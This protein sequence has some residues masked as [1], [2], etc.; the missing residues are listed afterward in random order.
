MVIPDSVAWID[1]WAFSRCSSLTSINIPDGVTYIGEYAF[2]YCSSLTSVVIPDSVTSIGDS[3]F[4]YCSSLINITIGGNNQY[5]KS[6]GS[7]L[8]TNDGK[9]LVQYAIGKEDTSF[10][11]PDNVTS[12]GSSAFSGCDSLTSVVIPDSVAWID[13]WAFSY[14][15][16]L[17]SIN[18]PD[19]VTYIGEYA[20]SYCH[21]LINIT[22]PDSIASMGK[23]AF[24]NNAY[25]NNENNWVDGVLYIGNHLIE[26]KDPILGEY[27]I[28]DGTISIADDA[29]YSCDSLTSVVIPDSVTSIGSYAFAGC[30]SLIS[31]VIPDS[32]VSIDM[33]AFYGCNN[34]TSITVGVNNPNY[35]SID[36]NLYSKDEKTF[37]QYAI[38]K[39]DTSFEIPDSVTSIGEYAFGACS[40]LTN[41]V[42]PDSVISIVDLAFYYCSSLT[43]VVIPDSVT[44][45]GYQAFKHCYNLTDV[46][47]TGTKTEGEKINISSDN[48]YLKNATIHYNYVPEE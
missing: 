19:S 29:F 21:S 13:D 1:D 17:T 46:Y 9:T 18:I 40:S 26:A 38:G 4:G 34:L 39:E 27:V 8:Y 16:S 33:C 6:I 28:K 45:I 11:I 32:V 20:F 48:Y 25:Y 47:Y 36:G 30:D 10:N 2:S 41:V 3:A 7:N 35:M 14:C 42:I 44:S 15:S 5:F 37:I 23:Y 24:Y 22:I 31:V 12:I 43:S